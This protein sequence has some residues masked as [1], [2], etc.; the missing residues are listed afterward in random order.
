MKPNSQSQSGGLAGAPQ[1]NSYQPAQPNPSTANTPQQ[2]R[3]TPLQ[4]EAAVNVLRSQIDS[5]YG[6]SPVASPAPA[7]QQAVPTPSH[8]E[9][10]QQPQ[11]FDQTQLQQNLQ[12]TPNPYDRSVTTATQQH[13]NIDQ[14]Q[15]KDYHSAW[16]E[17]Y[18]KYYEAYYEY[19]DSQKQTRRQQI[20]SE[21]NSQPIQ[22]AEQS[23]L[24]KQITAETEGVTSNQALNDLRN[25]LLDTVKTRAQKVKKSRHFMPAA[26]ALSVVLLF[27]FLQY[28]RVLL[29]N[30]S[31]YVSPGSIDPQNIIVNPDEAAVVS[32]ESRLIIPKI[33]V[34]VPAIFG[35]S[36]DH[37]SQM[38]AMEKG[39]AHFPI[40]GANSRPGE[41]GNTVLS[42]HSSNDLFDQGEYKFIFAQLEKLTEG[43]TIYINYNSVRYT[44][45]VTKKEVVKPS[46]VDK[47]V[48][49]TDKPVLTLITCTPLGTSL[50]RLLVTAE[51][52]SP[53]PAKSAEAPESDGSA[54]AAPMPGNS[55]TLLERLFGKR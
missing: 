26:I 32:D 49:P 21:L 9:V 42:G 33:N 3:T 22:T 20:N 15:W 6:D 24:A 1:G 53:D 7:Q 43:D 16:Q 37:N 8:S 50:N 13:T 44:Y 46:Q 11:S 41:K 36:P 51:Q 31:A 2:G 35:V 29:A 18:Q 54:D 47:L 12:N 10:Q 27:L 23:Q 28:N 55:A 19:Q 30:V 40:A 14:A 45:T 4:Q 5:L 39:V 52:V 48:Y 25:R 38:A 17:Y 34:D